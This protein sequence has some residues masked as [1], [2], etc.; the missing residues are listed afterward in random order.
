MSW[1][2]KVEEGGNLPN[3]SSDPFSAWHG[4]SY[5]GAAAGPPSTGNPSSAAK[6]YLT[7][8]RGFIPGPTRGAG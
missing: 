6:P 2:Q 7:R 5:E 4:G 3:P 1:R 8:T